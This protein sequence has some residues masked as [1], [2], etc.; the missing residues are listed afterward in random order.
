MIDYERVKHFVLPDVIQEYTARDTMLYAISLGFGS[1]PCDSR[2][3]QFVY[4]KNLQ[5]LPSMVVVLATPGSWMRHPEVGINYLRMVHAEQSVTFHAPLPVAATVI[6]RSRVTHVVDRGLEKGAVVQTERTLHDA[7]TGGLLATVGMQ[8]VCRSDGGFATSAQPGDAMP[9]SLPPVPE[10]EA[11]SQIDLATQPNAALLYRLSGDYNALHADPDV[12]LAAGFPRP[13][14]HG[15]AT[16]GIALRALTRG[17]LQGDLARLRSL[18]IRFSNPV[19]PG[20]TLRT[21]IWQRGKTICLRMLALERNVV[22][23]S[24]GL[25]A[26]ADPAE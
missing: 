24:T 9:D 21:L 11:D 19:F 7:T 18:R 2:E 13:I 16:Y 14:L 1:D 20:D 8:V 22:A 12:A 4:E 5:A 25:A 10:D 6:G 3:L 23:I 15:L 26:I 17:P